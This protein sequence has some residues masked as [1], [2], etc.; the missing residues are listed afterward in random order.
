FGCLNL[1]RLMATVKRSTLTS[2]S[3]FCCYPTAS[4]R[5]KQVKEASTSILIYSRAL[6]AV[7]MASCK[8]PSSKSPSPGMQGT[9]KLPKKNPISPHLS[10]TIAVIDQEIEF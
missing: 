10:R 9:R 4:S 7:G 8:S 1:N 3:S 5:V 6:T 2:I